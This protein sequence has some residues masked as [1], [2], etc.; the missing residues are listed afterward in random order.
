MRQQLS[1]LGAL[2]RVYHPQAQAGTRYAHERS[3]PLT[4]QPQTPVPPARFF[5][6][7]FG[8][9]RRPRATLERLA[10]LPRRP[11]GRMALAIVVAVM[12]PVVATYSITS[13][14]AAASFESALSSQKPAPGPVRAVPMAGGVVRVGPSGAGMP[15]EAMPALRPSPL[16]GLALPALGRLGGLVANWLLWSGVLYVLGTMMG[17]RNTFGHMLHMV[18]WTWAPFA[19]RGLLQAAYIVI[20]KEP[21]AFQGLSGLAVAEAPIAGIPTSPGAGT[22]VWQS[23]LGRIDIYLFWHLALVVVGLMAVAHLPRRKAVT[24]ALSS[25]VLLTLLGLLPNVI[26]GSFAGM[27]RIG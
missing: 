14:Q 16:M 23:F 1:R 18:V 6:L 5:G 2:H 27:G 12:L 22:L 25:W 26:L 11:W 9:L 10:E 20:T 19:V 24:L 3:L 4:E 7:L 13:S 15:P 17:G 21:I 8:I